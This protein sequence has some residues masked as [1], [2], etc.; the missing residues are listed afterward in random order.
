[1]DN[2]Y[3]W[4]QCLSK[5]CKEIWSTHNPLGQD[6]ANF[7]FYFV[8]VGKYR[9]GYTNHELEECY[10]AIWRELNFFIHKTFFKISKCEC[11]FSDF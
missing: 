6:L 7:I 11:E 2:D 10:W 8:V 4:V 9:I 5:I 3:S 1:M